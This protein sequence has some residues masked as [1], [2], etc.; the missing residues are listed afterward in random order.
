[1]KCL[2]TMI[3][4]NVEARKR[5]IT[6]RMDSHRSLLTQLV[7]GITHYGTALRLAGGPLASLGSV[8]HIISFRV[9]WEVMYTGITNERKQSSIRTTENA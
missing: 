8:E 2:T 7:G 4:S 5:H 9:V 6:Y 3:S 1:L